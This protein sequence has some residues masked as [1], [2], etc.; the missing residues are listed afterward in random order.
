MRAVKFL[1][2][3]AALTLSACFGGKPPP[4]LL[5]LTPS[6]A[7]VAIQRSASAGQAVTIDLPLVARE[8]RQVRVPVL[9]RPGQITYIKGL[10]YT[11]TPDLL[12]QALVSETVRR[13]TNRVVLE[14]GQS[15]LD[16]GL[17]VGGTLQRFGYDMASG[18]VTVTYDAVLSTEGGT[19][20]ETRRFEATAPAD[21]TPATVGPALNQA[22]N[23]V[24]TQV[25][26]WIGG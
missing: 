11:A 12:F 2:V 14:P 10:Q 25:A 9:E 21:G 13:T 22:A 24:A 18:Q 3:A 4:T 8:I 16:P 17:R 23:S 6:A 1:P 19:K 20:V 5:T 26:G 7:P 15:T